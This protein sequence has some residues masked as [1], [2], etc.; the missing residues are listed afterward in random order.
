MY[1]PLMDCERDKSRVVFYKMRTS[2][3][4]GCITFGVSAEKVIDEILL[5][6]HL[7]SSSFEAED[8]VKNKLY[9]I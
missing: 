7:L 3:K 9:P 2:T 8:L 5:E 1:L 6:I 4:L